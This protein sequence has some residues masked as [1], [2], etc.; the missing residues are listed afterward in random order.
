MER[1]V[2][3]SGVLQAMAEDFVRYIRTV[4]DSDAGINRK[5]G[6]N[7]L[8]TSRIYDQL[9]SKVEQ[10]GS[11]VVSMLLNDY[12]VYIEN[13]RRP[14]GKFPPVKPILDWCKRKGLP[15]D[16]STVF[17]I[18]RAIARDGISPRPIMGKVFDMIDETMPDRLDELFEAITKLLD[19][20]FN[21]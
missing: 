16:N 18:R 17:L 6:M 8:S 20:F 11:A 3:I 12:V 21:S 7:T 5:V 14:G 15:T 2:D 13:G 10:G 19:E 1:S 4:M 9:Q